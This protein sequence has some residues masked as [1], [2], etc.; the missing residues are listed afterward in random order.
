MTEIFGWSRAELLKQ[1]TRILYVHGDEFE[2]LGREAYP[3][4]V[5]G[6]TYRADLPAR[7]R[8]GSRFWVR[9]VGQAI[10]PEATETI[11]IID[12]ID[13]EKALE[14]EM[15]LAGDAADAANRAKSEFLANMS[16]EIRTPLNAVI[17]LTR[18][19]LDT[20]LDPEQHN[21][22]EKIDLSAR[23]LLGVINDIL[24]FSQIEAG[25][26]RLDR[27][28][29][30]LDAIV[31]QIGVILEIPV[32][33]KGLTLQLDVP[34]DAPRNLLGDGSRLTQV[35]L[36]LVGNAVK[37]TH[38]GT[39]SL[40]VRVESVSEHEARLGFE[41]TDTGIG[42]PADQ[43][44]RLFDAFTQ[45]DSSAR[46]AQSGSGL[47]LTISARLVALMGGSLELA[48]EPGV[49]SRFWF[50]LSFMRATTDELVV[51]DGEPDA[52]TAEREPSL[53]TGLEAGPN[54]LHGIRVLVAEDDPINRLFIHDLLRR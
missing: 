47:G 32:A 37:F 12:D 33:D 41:V 11:W 3:L 51:P 1:S 46:R 19:T 52:D 50:A 5:R 43:H 18:L 6:G 21:Y 7:R 42:I 54:L 15:R 17:G 10:D 22:L 36:N 34:A 25:E 9:V 29:L 35:L 39:V 44:A 48:S 20:D 45:V 23:A 16:H 38:R 30:N 2:R 14:Q 49:G 27:D 13:R 24:D 26:L 31:E 40:R 8:D 53:E 28:G 4:L